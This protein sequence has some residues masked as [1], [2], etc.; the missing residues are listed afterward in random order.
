MSA[1]IALSCVLMAP[2][3]AEAQSTIA[4][5]TDPVATAHPVIVADGWSG[6]VQCVVTAQALGYQDSQTHTWVLRGAPVVRNDFPDYPATWTVNGGGS[7]TL[8]AQ[9]T[10]ATGASESW[11]RSGVVAQSDGQRREPGQAPLAG[12]TRAAD[13]CAFLP[14]QVAGTF[15]SLAASLTA[16]FDRRTR[17]LDDRS[18]MLMDDRTLELATLAVRR[19]AAITDVD[20]DYYD[21]LIAA[22][23]KKYEAQL[24][25]IAATRASLIKAVATMQS[26]LQKERQGVIGQVLKL[27]EKGAP[28]SAAIDVFRHD[29]ES[30]LNALALEIDTLLGEEKTS[31]LQR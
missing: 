31:P 26:M 3:I 11:T 5:G 4:T 28:S 14:T 13:P 18:K 17:E 20:R 12:S 27:C 1:R 9:R 24:S 21:G 30:L 10:A 8:L 25:E 15:D 19:Q 2:V 7:R 23:N 29:L 6:H 16:S 22:A